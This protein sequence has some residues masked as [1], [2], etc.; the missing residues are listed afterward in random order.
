ME[1]KFYNA[2]TRNISK[3]YN[4]IAYYIKYCVYTTDKFH[5]SIVANEFSLL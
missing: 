4:K 5:I 2:L 3:Q 1:R